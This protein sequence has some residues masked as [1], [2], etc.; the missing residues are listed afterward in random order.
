MKEK[1]LPVAGMCSLLD[2]AAVFSA[3]KRALLLIF[4]DHG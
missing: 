4:I 1:L 2:I 3:S